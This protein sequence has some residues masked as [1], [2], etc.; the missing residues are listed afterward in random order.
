MKFG[1]VQFP[2]SNCDDDAYH[3][4]GTVLGQPVE[5]I[6]HQSE[7]VAGFDAIIL[8]G[9]FAFG[10]YLRT[11]A[12]ARFSPVMRAVS[13]FARSGG[14]VLGICNGFQILLEAGLLPGAMVRN[15]GLRFLCR[16][17]HVR[18]ES[19][20]TPF[21]CAARQA[22]VLKIPIAHME[23]NYFCDP[24][25]LADLERNRQIVFRYVNADASAGES[26]S[27]ASGAAR[28]T[29]AASNA[30][31][32]ADDR[33]TNPNGSLAAI[34]GICNRERNVVGLMPHPER[35]VEAALGSSDG[36]VI[37]S[38]MIESLSRRAAER[39]SA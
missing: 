20:D 18:V 6:W 29:H 21:T 9:G 4:I 7:N 13:G 38:S 14:P 36:L 8:P 28:T 19:T 26:P 5:F 33:D 24:A 37:F 35:A 34:A 12:I 3:A 16:Q 17:V 30:S 2:G 31:L 25:A 22:Q 15:K 39:V 1:V 27:N 32:A 23:G 11:G 10:D